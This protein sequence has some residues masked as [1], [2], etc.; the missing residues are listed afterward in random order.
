MLV[1]PYS[2]PFATM[3]QRQADEAL[4]NAVG[5]S[6]A[7]W[8]ALRPPLPQIKYLPPRF[9]YPTYVE[10]QPTILQV[11]GISRSPN[12]AIPGF[13]QMRQR[14]RVDYSQ[15]QGRDQGSDR[16]SAGNTGGVGNGS[17]GW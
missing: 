5:P 6:D 16:L 15:F 10:R 1:L 13:P 17:E 4:E 2:E 7:Y 3:Y 11:F 12:G 14:N 9:G 8:R